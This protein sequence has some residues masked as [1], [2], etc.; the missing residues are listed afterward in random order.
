MIRIDSY[1]AGGVFLTQ[2]QAYRVK[3]ALGHLWYNSGI[4]VLSSAAPSG[5]QLYQV[6][7]LTFGLTPM[8]P[9]TSLLPP[10][11]A[12]SLPSFW[13]ELSYSA[14]RSERVIRPTK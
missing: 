14:S 2:T 13:P 11:C 1:P 4:A 3:A 8:A 6:V 5:S 7:N 12:L 10:E 9:R